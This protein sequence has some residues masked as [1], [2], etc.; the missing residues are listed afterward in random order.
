MATPYISPSTTPL[1]I[2]PLKSAPA[3]PATLLKHLT[4]FLASS[5]SANA[6]SSTSHVSTA[7]TAGIS[8]DVAYQLA[9]L[10]KNVQWQVEGRVDSLPV[11]QGAEKDAA[12]TESAPAETPKKK[13]AKKAGSKWA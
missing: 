12:V 11:A 8:P 9:A 2:T 7:A 4:A 6:G 10:C 5:S 3:P 13:K 1:H